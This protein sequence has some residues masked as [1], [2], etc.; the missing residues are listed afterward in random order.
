[1]KS[2]FY[3][4]EK[5]FFSYSEPSWNLYEIS[6]SITPGEIIGI[7]GPNG[8][9]KSTLIKLMAGIIKPMKGK[10]LL[11]GN[12]INSIPRKDFAKVVGYL[13]QNFQGEFDFTVYDVISLGRYPFSK[14]FAFLNHEDE[15]VIQQCMKLTDTITLKD[16]RLSNLS[17]GERQRVFLASVLAQKPSILILDEP[18]TGLD[19]HHQV[20]IL[21]LLKSLIKDGVSVVIATHEIN[22]AT[23]F[24]TRLIL[25]KEGR[26]IIDSSPKEVVTQK[27]MEE[28]YG[29]KI[30]V[31]IHPKENIPFLL[32]NN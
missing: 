11:D 6:F 20:E 24:C 16:R 13:P 29:H 10:I 2:E 7:I 18:T 32:P 28:I 3:Q 23:L 21:N 26:L 8:S 14:G 22:L 1:M 30:Y 9:G 12:S 25:L 17:G 15:A 19:I 5:V 31:G 27:R 4:I